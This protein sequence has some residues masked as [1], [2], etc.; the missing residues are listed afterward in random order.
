MSDI[1][2]SN[3]MFIKLYGKRG[4]YKFIMID[5]EDFDKISNYKWNC[6]KGYN[7]HYAVSY[8]RNYKKIIRL[9]RLVMDDPSNKTG[10][11]VDH[12]DG[13]GLNNTKNNLRFCTHA[14]NMA[15]QRR[16][17]RTHVTSKYKGG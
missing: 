3:V 17:L 12:I 1:D 9:H 2:Y 14:K 10:M 5:R 8:C 13:D 11:L 15:N 6:I 7:T 4:K 16:K